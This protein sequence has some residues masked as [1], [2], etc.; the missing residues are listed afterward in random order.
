MTEHARAQWAALRR[1]TADGTLGGAR[2]GSDRE[3][4]ETSLFEVHCSCEHGET[5]FE[6]EVSRFS[7]VLIALN[8][9]GVRHRQA[10]MCACSEASD[11]DIARTAVEAWRAAFAADPVIPYLGTDA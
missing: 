5:A 7:G 2:D 3:A 4:R 6:V 8:V 10:F 11:E 9:L 1:A